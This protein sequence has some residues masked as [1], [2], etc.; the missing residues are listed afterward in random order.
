M[1]YLQN[2]QDDLQGLDQDLEE[3]LSPLGYG[4]EGSYLPS[5]R[6]L[7]QASLGYLDGDLYRPQ[8]TQGLF[9]NLVPVQVP[10]FQT[11]ISVS[12][13]DEAAL[14]NERINVGIA[15]GMPRIELAA[16]QQWSRMAFYR[17]KALD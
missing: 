2:M 13:A 11:G 10:L 8:A 6:S 16:K 5:F 17:L 9:P 12:G 14:R 4:F 3:A 1:T 15:I 7:Q